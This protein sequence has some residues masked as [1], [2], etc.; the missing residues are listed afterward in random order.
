MASSIEL[1]LENKQEIIDKLNKLKGEDLKKVMQWSLKRM[2]NRGP[3]IIAKV[4]AERYEIARNKLNPRT[5]AGKG[6]VSASGGDLGSIEWVYTGKR[7][8]I[9]TGGEGETG[10]HV[11]P[12]A[13]KFS[14]YDVKTKILKGQ[15][16]FFGHWD[17]PFSEGGAYGPQSPWMIPP[18]FGFPLMR[19]GAGF[20]DP[21]R[22]PSVPQMVLNDYTRDH[23]GEALTEAAFKVLQSNL[24]RLLG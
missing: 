8:L 6:T 17:F 3:S 11:F 23:L 24:E 20:G 16:S 21:A 2:Q 9:G 15:N 14:R 22:G 12:K 1:T 5:K 19:V 4:A 10:F 18:G 7:L 13:H